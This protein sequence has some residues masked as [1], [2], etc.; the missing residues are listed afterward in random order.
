MQPVSNPLSGFR[1]AA[2]LFDCTVR[3]VQPH[4]P[5]GLK[6]CRARTATQYVPAALI[7]TALGIEITKSPPEPLYDW[8]IR[9]ARSVSGSVVVALF[10]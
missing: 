7:E 9:Q 8:L 10:V 3:T 6:F 1:Q 2:P 4:W 5:A